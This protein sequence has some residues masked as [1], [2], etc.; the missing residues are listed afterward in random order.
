MAKKLDQVK[1]KDPKKV[2]DDPKLLHKS[3]H[4]EKKQQ[5]N[6]KKWKDRI[7]TRNQLKVEKQ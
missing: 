4:K 2:H 7:Q 5:T 1:K 3:I 6:A